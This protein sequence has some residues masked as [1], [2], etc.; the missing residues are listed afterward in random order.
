MSVRLSA[1]GAATI[2][3]SARAAS[4][5]RSIGCENSVFATSGGVFAGSLNAQ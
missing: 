1:R 2:F 3:F 4:R 5:N